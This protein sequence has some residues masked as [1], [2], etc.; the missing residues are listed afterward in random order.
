MGKKTEMGVVVFQIFTSSQNQMP[1]KPHMEIKH[2]LWRVIPALKIFI[3]W[4]QRIID[5]DLSV[6]IC[7]MPEI[8][9]L[10]I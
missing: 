8:T 4:L 2:L 7:L 9:D 1:L 5:H 10:H 6:L 3:S